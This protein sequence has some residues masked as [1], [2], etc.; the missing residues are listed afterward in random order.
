M[1][2][3]MNISDFIKTKREEHNL[4]QRQLA[5]LCGIS[6]T[7]VWQIENGKRKK[8]Q[9]LILKAMAPHLNVSYEELMKIAGY[10]SD[11]STFN[12]SFT[13]KEEL[14]EYVIEA[15]GFMRFA[16]SNLNENEFKTMLQMAKSYYQ[17]I[18][19]AKSK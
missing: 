2:E 7:E 3:N 18:M 11:E 16:Y 15:I 8:V 17:T 13:D 14:P 9:P 5:E 12:F 10:I 19:E 6:N 1:N 4:S